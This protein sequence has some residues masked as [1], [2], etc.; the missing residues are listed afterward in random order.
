MK[1]AL[2]GDE[3]AVGGG[4]DGIPDALHGR[5]RPADH[6]GEVEDVGRPE[7]VDVG[8]PGEPGDGPRGQVGRASVT[9]LQAPKSV[10]EATG[11]L[12]GGS[13]GSR[14]CRGSSGR[15]QGE[16]RVRL[17]LAGP[18]DEARRGGFGT[19]RGAAGDDHWRR[20][21]TGRGDGGT[22][23]DGGLG[24]AGH[25]G[26]GP[27]GWPP[28]ERRCPAPPS[29]PPPRPTPRPRRERPD[30]P[31]VAPRPCVRLRPG[32]RRRSSARSYLS[33]CW[34]RPSAPPPPVHGSVRLP[35]RFERL[36]KN[37]GH[38]GRVWGQPEKSGGKGRDFRSRS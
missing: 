12:T 13:P 36:G 32:P 14:W 18:D 22:G 15:R 31:G 25:R 20:D 3:R 10:A 21:R 6:G 2:A 38:L 33:V 16:E 24:P 17:V 34:S 7:P 27:G 35:P 26:S 9:G 1:G 11:T 19:R 29:P 30:G 8:G 37:G 5:R 23:C 28:R 4:P